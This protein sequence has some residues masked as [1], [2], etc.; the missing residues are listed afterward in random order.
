MYNQIE[1]PGILSR[2]SLTNS[3]NLGAGGVVFG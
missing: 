1:D 2:V 3:G